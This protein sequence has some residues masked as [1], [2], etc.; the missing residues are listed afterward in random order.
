MVRFVS[1]MLADESKTISLKEDSSE[2]SDQV[3]HTEDDTAD[4]AHGEVRSTSVILYGR[5]GGN[6]GEQIVHSPGRT[7]LV[8]GAVDGEGEDHDDDEQ[9]RGVGVVAEKGSTHASDHDVDG[10]TDRDE[11]ASRDGVHASQ[12]GD[13]SGTT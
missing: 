4:G 8:G 3:D 6:L 13:G 1:T 2:V 7:D 10:D 11:E 9:H 5:D 12:V